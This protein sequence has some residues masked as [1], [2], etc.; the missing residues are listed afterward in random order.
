MGAPKPPTLRPRIAYRDLAADPALGPWVRRIG[1][2]RIGAEAVD[3]FA[4]LVR[5]IVYQQLAGRAA[6]T[7]HG[8]VVAA[9]GGAVTP[10][11]LQR[12]SDQALRDAGLSRN[13]L[14][15]IRDLQVR[16]RALELDAL[17]A[18]SDG[19]IVERLTQV[20]GIGPWTVQM[21]LIF[22][23]RRADVWPAGDLGVRNGYARVHGL[24]GAPGAR[25]LERLGDVYRPWRSAAAWYFWQVL[26]VETP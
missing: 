25:Q 24:E 12:T 26:D 20:R 14:A 15:S 11:R 6:A 19:D 21:L 4:Y 3:P 7:I 23:L 17:P 1:M 2:P 16:H 8:R 9:L 13:K 5:S 18:M 10:R 22:G